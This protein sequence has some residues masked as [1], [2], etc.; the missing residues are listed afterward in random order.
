M[1]H[2]FCYHLTALGGEPEGEAPGSIH[3][4]ARYEGSCSPERHVRRGQI[5]PVIA[6]STTSTG[7]SVLIAVPE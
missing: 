5:R 3:V 6:F 1:T 4:T 2:R 7:A